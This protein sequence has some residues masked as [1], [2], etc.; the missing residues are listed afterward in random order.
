MTL[1]GH[2]QPIRAELDGQAAPALALDRMDFVISERGY[3]VSFGSKVYD[4]GSFTHT[5]S[6]LRMTAQQG[7][8]EGRVVAAIYQL[9]GDRLRVCYALDGTAPLEFKTAPGSQ[10]YLVTYRRLIAQSANG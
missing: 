9:V 10:R 2:W 6:T 8:N 7:P 5:D 1:Y 3:T 4:S